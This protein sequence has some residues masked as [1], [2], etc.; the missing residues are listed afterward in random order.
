MSGVGHRG[1]V[2]NYPDV[3]Y[4]PTLLDS[5]WELIKYRIPNYFSLGQSYCLNTLVKGLEIKLYIKLLSFWICVV[6]LNKIFFFFRL[7]SSFP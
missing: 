6:M 2:R 4:T 7:I 1:I 5:H 3:N